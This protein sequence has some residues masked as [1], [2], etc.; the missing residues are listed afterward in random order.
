MLVVIMGVKHRCLDVSMHKQVQAGRLTWGDVETAAP[1]C[2]ARVLVAT[3]CAAAVQ[4]H[5]GALVCHA[6]LVRVYAHAGHARH[7]K[8]KRRQ[9]A[10]QSRPDMRPHGSTRRASGPAADSQMKLGYGLSNMRL[11]DEN[12]LPAAENIT[13]PRCQSCTSRAKSKY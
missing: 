5:A 8:V 2:D 11:K 7:G 12:L 13:M 1:L 6:K 4:N 10:A 3:N 9:R